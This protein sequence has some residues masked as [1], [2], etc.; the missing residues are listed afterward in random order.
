[1]ASRVAVGLC[2]SGRIVFHAWQQLDNG[3][4][5]SV[6][7]VRPLGLEDLYNAEQWNVSMLN[8]LQKLGI[9]VSKQPTEA[10]SLIG[11]ADAD[12]DCG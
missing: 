11:Q 5:Q 2:W 8:C 10:H 4:K 3:L 7:S 6:V 12:W 9:R 1:M